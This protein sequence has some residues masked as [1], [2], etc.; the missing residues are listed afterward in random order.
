ME[1][2]DATTV[3]VAGPGALDQGAA[4]TAGVYGIVE[5]TG[6][7]E[8]EGEVIGDGTGGGTDVN[9][10]PTTT[11]GDT[12]AVALVNSPAFNERVITGTDIPPTAVSMHIFPDGSYRYL[13]ERG[14]YLGARL[15]SSIEGSSSSI[16]EAP[17]DDTNSSEPSY[18]LST[19][20]ISSEMY[21]QIQLSQIVS[22]ITS[23]MLNSYIA[24]GSV[25]RDGDLLVNEAGTVMGKV[26]SPGADESATTTHWSGEEISDV[27]HIIKGNEI[28]MVEGYKGLSASRIEG[29]LGGYLNIEGEYLYSGQGENR[30]II[31]VIE[32]K[33][34]L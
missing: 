27:T 14:L 10:R 2:Q 23:E 6:D 13:D 24:E 31:G 20:N 28:Q 26:L 9:L 16:Y 32:S 5:D 8:G 33:R 1:T 34:G 22:G 30:N 19:N 4:A 15:G 12:P 17:A 3:L 18:H 25:F 7:Y 11:H 29:L 21:G